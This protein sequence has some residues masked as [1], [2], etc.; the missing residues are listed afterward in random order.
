MLQI[1]AQRYVSFDSQTKDTVTAVAMH[2]LHTELGEPESSSNLLV[3][4]DEKK[5]SLNQLIKEEEDDIDGIKVP[6]ETQ[7]S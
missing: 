2:R 5:P 4:K 1:A 6:A 3:K 7:P